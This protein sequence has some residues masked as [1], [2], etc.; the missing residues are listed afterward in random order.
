[1][2]FG[3]H[4]ITDI[5]AIISALHESLPVGASHW[6]LIV[7]GITFSVLALVVGMTNRA[8]ELGY[9]NAFQRHKSAQ[10]HLN[11]SIESYANMIR[12]H[13]EP[14][15]E[16][17]RK[18]YDRL[19]QM[20]NDYGEQVAVEGM[21]VNWYSRRIEE[22][23]ESYHYSVRKY[24]D[25]IEEL[26]NDP[27]PAYFPV[28]SKPFDNELLAQMNYPTQLEEKEQRI[29]SFEDMKAELREQIV[30][31]KHKLYD[32]RQS[33]IQKAVDITKVEEQL[34]KPANGAE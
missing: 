29:Q 24:R 22:I 31:V 8:F 4:G 5:A 1:M 2:M 10:A 28:I 33:A 14:Y 3:D 6:T 26:S 32:L 16:A 30:S 18:Q 11:A 9:S 27:P 7:V 34:T 13:I 15:L 17:P 12:N 25:K 20:M 19:C 21:A 23:N